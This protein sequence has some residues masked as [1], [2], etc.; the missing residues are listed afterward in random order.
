MR[1]RCT[2]G[3]LLVCTYHIT[4][5]FEYGRVP[6]R[7]VC[8]VKSSKRTIFVAETGQRRPK[9]TGGR[10]VKPTVLAPPATSMHE[11][12]TQPHACTI[13]DTPHRRT[14]FPP[15]VL[16]AARGPSACTRPK[17]ET[18]RFGV[19]LGQN[20][21]TTRGTRGLPQQLQCIP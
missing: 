8:R 9:P 15:G 14:L 10:A 7:G 12:L 6:S 13:V 17:R 11:T 16:G 4:T 1:T 2:P 18:R 5:P 20:S 19:E 21:Q 3:P